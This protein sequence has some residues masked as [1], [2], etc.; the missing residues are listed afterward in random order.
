[1]WFRKTH[2][3]SK[4]PCELFYRLFSLNQEVA[5]C[6]ESMELQPEKSQFYSGF[7]NPQSWWELEEQGGEKGTNS[8]RMNFLISNMLSIQIT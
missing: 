6:Q 2:L 1:M 4:K 8:N 3:I 7:W 5:F